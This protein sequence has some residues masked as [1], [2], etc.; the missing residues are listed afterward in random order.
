[1]IFSGSRNVKFKIRQTHR[2]QGMNSAIY[3]SGLRWCLGR[4]CYFNNTNI[5]NTEEA[6]RAVVSM[7][8]KESIV[9]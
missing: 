7:M 5:R 1:M 9:A 6:R 4:E 8:A 2:Y 3:G